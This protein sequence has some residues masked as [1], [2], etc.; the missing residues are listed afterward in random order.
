MTG[1]T[2]GLTGNTEFMVMKSERG[3]IQC[4]A[5]MLR[6]CRHSTATFRMGRNGRTYATILQNP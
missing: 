2:E 1:E 6:H 4:N 5:C 3:N